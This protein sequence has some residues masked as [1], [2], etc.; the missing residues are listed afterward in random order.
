MSS[1]PVH[2]PANVSIYF[3]AGYQKQE[4]PAEGDYLEG[5][6]VDEAKLLSFIKKKAFNHPPKTGKRLAVEKKPKAA[7]KLGAAKAKRKRT[8]RQ[9]ETIKP[10]VGT[11]SK[12]DGDSGLMISYNTVK[13][14][15]SANNELWDQ[16][17][18]CRLHI[19]PRPYNDAIKRSK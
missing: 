10:E 16:Q 6:V 12:E 17:V 1:L 7:G 11:D 8:D 5:D 2:T 14:Y 3:Q 19:G 18:A 13:G 15:C 4:F 9:E